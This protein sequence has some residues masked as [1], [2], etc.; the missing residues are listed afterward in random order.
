MKNTL[1]TRVG[2]FVAFIVLAAILIIEILGGIDQ[3]G[4]GLRVQANFNSVQELKVGDR[5][6]M[7]G[8]EVGRVEGI[9]LTNNAVSV[10]MRL[11]RESVVRTDSIATIKFAGLLGQNYV[12]LSFGSPGAPFA[13]DATI[14]QSEEQPDLSVIMRKLDN[15]ASGVENLTRSFT[16]DEIGNLLG[17]LTDFVKQNSESL[18]LTIT[19]ISEITGQISSGQGTFGKL[20]YDE[21]LHASSVAMMT[22]L[23]HAVSGIQLTIADAQSIM[24]DVK[25][26]QGT[27]GKLLYDDALYQETTAS[28]TNLREILQKINRGEG[29]VGL[30]VNDEQFYNNAKLTLQKMEKSVESLEDTGPLSVLGIAVGSLF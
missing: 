11:N 9:D 14:L 27:V 21:S 7:A 22:N 4:G 23:Q 3:F 28:M 20:I 24:S 18:G 30:L 2:L 13:A 8:V 10:T 6:K 15:V 25:A 5:V 12:D 17:P 16:G 1:E 29:S 26:G 19:H